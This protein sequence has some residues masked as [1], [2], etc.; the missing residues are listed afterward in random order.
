MK[1][2]MV[3]LG[4]ICR[5]P[6][7]EG[8]LKHYSKLNNLNWIIESAGTAGYHVG[9]APHHQSQKVA[10]QFGIDI[11]TQQ[12]RKFIKDDIS[13]YDIIY[14]MDKENYIDVK[15]ICEEKWNSKKVKLILNELY[16]NENREVPDPWN[17][18]DADFLDVY[19]L[20]DNACK[21]IINNYCAVE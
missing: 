18:T 14:V 16:P 13:F 11:S 12:C 10:S 19:N 9:C 5:S 3:C 7:A 1:I 6:L 2:L 4:N 8:I 21:H 17:G 20:L 15:N